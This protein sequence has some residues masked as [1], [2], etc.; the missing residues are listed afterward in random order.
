[1]GLS[2]QCWIILNCFS[3]VHY[4]KGIDLAKLAKYSPFWGNTLILIEN[5]YNVWAWM[6]FES[7]AL[8]IN[9][10][11]RGLMNK[12][13]ALVAQHHQIR[14]MEHSL[15]IGSYNSTTSS[16]NSFYFNWIS[17]T[18]EFIALNK[19]CT[20]KNGTR[21][22]TSS[23]MIKSLLHKVERVEFHWLIYQLRSNHLVK[24]EPKL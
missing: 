1:M 11:F 19:E 8:F 23:K 22:Y 24:P 4:A 14:I 18:P 10:H 6:E 9:L 7:F 21:R 16:N 3:R 13:E 2:L 17:P 12:S 5:Q 20:K 15:L